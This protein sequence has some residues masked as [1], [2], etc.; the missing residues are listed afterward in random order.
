M[1]RFAILFA[2][3]FESYVYP[4]L[5]APLLE[6]YEM[7]FESVYV[8]LHPFIRVPEE[9]SWKSRRTYPSGA[10]ILAHGT[11]C[12][13]AEAARGAGIANCARMSQ[14][15]LTSIHSIED[16]LCDYAASEALVRYLQASPVWMPTE[17]YFEE[18]LE[19]D[20]LAAFEGAGCK[21]LVYVPEFPTVDPIARFSIDSLKRRE[22]KFPARGS[23]VAPDES[24]LFTVDWDSFFTLF[25]GP[26]AFVEEVVKSRG[27]E[28]FFAEKE[29]EHFWFNWKM[30]CATCTVSPEGW[31]AG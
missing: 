18:L 1:Q 25:Y 17:G 19:A 21:E 23:L 24:F 28:G 10:E 8:V 11:K 31:A 20:F 12:K 7:A 30:G 5:N 26:R 3:N 22:E 15:L 2:V 13:W 16:F 4:A 9:L 6:A 14:A 27:L 29:T